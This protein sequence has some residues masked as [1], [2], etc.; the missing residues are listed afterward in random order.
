MI[1][2]HKSNNCPA[3]VLK[4]MPFCGSFCIV[5]GGRPVRHQ[6][7]RFGKLGIQMCAAPNQFHPTQVESATSTRRT[8]GT[9]DIR[10][11]VI[12]NWVGPRAQRIPAALQELGVCG[13][14]ITDA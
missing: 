1:A 9:L 12:A 10:C 5:M 4:R 2:A 3:V 13:R 6:S 7:F 11:R 14:R 8:W